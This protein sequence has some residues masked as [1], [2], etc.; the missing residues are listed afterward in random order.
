MAA[1]FV[2]DGT[3]HQNQALVRSP[4][5]HPT[6]FAMIKP[7]SVGLK[8]RAAGMGQAALE[9]SL[10]A[11]NK[12]KYASCTPSSIGKTQHVTETP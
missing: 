2:E 5:R 1:D 7:P 11:E 12:G 3:A 10:D 4:L 6:F 8:K 9:T